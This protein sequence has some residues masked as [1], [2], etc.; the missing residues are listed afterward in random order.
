MLPRSKLIPLKKE[1]PRIRKDG[2]IY[3]Y[4]SF[5]LVVAYG[6]P[7]AGG[8]PQASFVVS[9]KVDK[10]S[11]VRHAIKRK[12]A[13]AVSPFFPRL[14]KS[15]ELVFLVDLPPRVHAI[16]M[17]RSPGMVQSLGCG[18]GLSVF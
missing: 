18:W 3:D 12:L 8:G 6:S 9:K 4:P 17:K 14:D 11:V 2:K 1:F 5:G 16:H 15:V 13:D 7:P 10:K